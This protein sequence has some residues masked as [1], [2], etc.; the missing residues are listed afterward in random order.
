MYQ[1]L[2]CTRYVSIHR[3][4]E[5]SGLAPNAPPLPH[6]EYQNTEFWTRLNYVLLHAELAG[7]YYLIRE[8][9]LHHA[10]TFP[11][12]S[13][14]LT[15]INRL[16]GVNVISQ[17]QGPFCAST[18]RK[19]HCGMYQEPLRLRTVKSLRNTWYTSARYT[20]GITHTH[21]MTTTAPPPLCNSFAIQHLSSS[22]CRRR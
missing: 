18:Q 16:A 4:R 17:Q 14:H 20:K 2:L 7:W 22:F 13:L 6:R 3:A 19:K 10:K 11:S 15:F 5:D 9:T 8:H 1:A 12:P 21:R